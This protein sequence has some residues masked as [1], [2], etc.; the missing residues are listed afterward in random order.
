M[1]H[2]LTGQEIIR[3]GRSY[4]TRDV[5]ERAREFARALY[6]PAATTVTYSQTQFSEEDHRLSTLQL[7]AFDASGQLLPYDFASPWW[8]GQQQLPADATTRAA[9]L[10]REDLARGLGAGFPDATRDA[11]RQFAEELLGVETLHSWLTWFARNESETLTW[12]FDLT[13]PPPVAYA[14]MTDETGAALAVSEI[15]AAGAEREALARW[16]GV[17]EYVHALYG[18]RAVRADVSAFSRYNDSTYDRDIKLDVFG[19]A[20][21]RLFYDLRLPWWQ[22]FA[23][24]EQEIA[25]YAR[26]HDPDEPTSAEYD[27][28]YGYEVD[29][30]A[31]GEIERL[32]TVLLG[33]DFI[34]TRSQWDTDTSSYD[35]T[36][37]PELRFPR[38]WT[39]DADR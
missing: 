12:M 17:R 38:L 39:E 30:R 14:S 10:A 33:A 4:E 15:I 13:T 25:T 2:E 21:T 11:L 31:G 19:A 37:A 23:F 27:S 24:S 35:L 29:T 18:E 32:A 5:W 9:E 16:S 34:E 6:G 3:A 36:R 26:E 1:R 7:L 8:A 20:G 22:R 28:A